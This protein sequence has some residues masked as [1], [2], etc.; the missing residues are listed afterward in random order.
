MTKTPLFFLFT[1]PSPKP[2]RN[3][4]YEGRA[5]ARRREQRFQVPQTPARLQ[6]LKQRREE[7]RQEVALRP[8]QSHPGKEAENERA[9]LWE[10]KEEEKAR[11]EE[12]PRVGRKKDD[13]CAIAALEREEERDLKARED[14]ERKKKLAN[15]RAAKSKVGRKGREKRDLKAVPDKRKDTHTQIHTQREKSIMAA[16]EHRAI[17]TFVEIAVL[18]SLGAMIARALPPPLEL[19]PKKTRKE[20][21]KVLEKAR[22]K[23]KSVL[24]EERGKKRDVEGDAAK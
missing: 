20:T 3:N 4:T 2:P 9:P 17:A 10:E 21:T 5:D 1:F 24:E 11:Q 6:E 12:R 16:E 13:R 8:R 7:I 23:K 15:R 14:K 22:R 19:D 18:V